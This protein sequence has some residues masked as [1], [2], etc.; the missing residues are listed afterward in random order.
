MI[1]ATTAISQVYQDGSGGYFVISQGFKCPYLNLTH[2]IF[3][4]THATIA[5]TSRWEKKMINT[6]NQSAIT[7]SF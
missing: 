2:S 7:I 3:S 5:P 1:T 6:N 4:H